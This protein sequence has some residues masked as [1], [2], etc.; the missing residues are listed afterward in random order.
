[1]NRFVIACFVLVALGLAACSGDHKSKTENDT[2]AERPS[3]TTQDTSDARA[4]FEALV[5]AARETTGSGEPAVWTLADEDTTLHI[6]GTVHVLKPQTQWRSA[7]INAAFE[8]AETI[9][10]EAD[11]SSQEAA[12]ELG[13][14]MF[15]LGLYQGGKTLEDV[16]SGAQQAEV[17]A[18]LEDMGLTF[19]AVKPM[20]PWFAALTL[21]NQAMVKQGFDPMSGVEMVLTEEAKADDKS[22][23]YLE[24]AADQLRILSG[25]DEE[26]QIDFLM[27]SVEGIEETPEMLDVLVEEWADGDVAGLSVMI[28]DPD[29]LGSD[30]VY[31]ALLKNRN[32]DWVPK[33]E[34]MLDEPGTRLIAVGA[35]HLAGDDSVILSL[36]DKGYEVTGP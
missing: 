15:Q 4:D 30:V 5:A 26:T 25:L 35:A 10:F 34:A 19:D 27:S 16:L 7:Q 17:S 2:Q 12:A 36:R 13:P 20:K 1:M 21:S 29:A 32:D 31:E 28:A 8:A 14:L 33:I 9:V 3:E 18:V 11:V 24:T 22:F 23:A 6:M